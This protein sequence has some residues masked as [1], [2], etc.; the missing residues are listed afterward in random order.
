MIAASNNGFKREALMNQSNRAEWLSAASF[1]RPPFKFHF[2]SVKFHPAVLICR[3]QPV[4][5][6]TVT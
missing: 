3:L 1:A 5:L 6:D 4:Y 2:N